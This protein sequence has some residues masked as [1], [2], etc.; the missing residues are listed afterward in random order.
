MDGYK[1]FHLFY[2]YIIFFDKQFIIINQPA[3]YKS[4]LGKKTKKKIL[5]WIDRCQ[6]LYLSFFFW[7]YLPVVPSLNFVIKE[8]CLHKNGLIDKCI[9]IKVKN[10]RETKKKRVIW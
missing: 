7:F 4:K 9:V 3:K 2:Y 6:V 5:N 8:K 10:S 1:K